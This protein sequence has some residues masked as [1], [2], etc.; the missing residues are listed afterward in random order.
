MRILLVQVL[1]YLLTSGGAHKA[2]RLLI[3]GFAARGHQCQVIAAGAA[4]AAGRAQLRA[5]LRARG[6]ELRA[7][8]P[9]EVVFQLNG[10][11]VHAVTGDFQ[12]YHRLLLE[13]AR[14]FAPDWVLVSEDRTFTLVELAIE[15]APGR[16][17]LLAHSQATL[18]FG[19]ESFDADPAKAR[20]LPQ[21]AGIISVSRYLQGY[22]REWGGCDAAVIPFPSYGDG[23][24][25]QLGRFDTGAVT[26]VNPA[27]IKGLPI[28]E[29]LARSLPDLP[30]AAVPTWASTATEIAALRQL[31][32]VAMYPQ[33]SDLDQ[34]FAQVR[35][36]LVPSLWG[37]SFG[38]VVVD[39]ML[40]GVPVLASAVGGLPEAKLGVDYL[41]PVEPIRAYAPQ[42]DVRST[43]MPII[44][45]QDV[46]PWRETLARLLSD[47]QLYE[48]VAAESRAAALAFVGALNV[49]RFVA[50][51]EQLHPAPLPAATASAAPEPLRARL[52]ALAPDRHA[53]LAL[54]L[55]QRAEAGPAAPAIPRLPRV[56][57]RPRFPISFAQQRLWFLHQLDPANPF[58]NTALSFELDAHAD[59]TL[60]QRSLDALAARHEALR[61]TLVPADGEP[62]QVINPPAPVPLAIADLRALPP[63]ERAA[64]AERLLAE[65][66]RAPFDLAQGPLLRALLLHTGDG[67]SRLL[68]VLHHII[69]DGWSVGVMAQDLDRCYAALAAGTPVD[70]PGPEIQYADYAVWQREQLRGE[71]LAQH[72]HY[73][74]GQF[75]EPAALLN[76]PT[77]RPR[78]AVKAYRGAALRRELPPPLRG[79]VERLSRQ[80]GATPFMTMLAVFA[81]LI[82]RSS[83]QTDLVIGTPIAGRTQRALEPVVGCFINMLPLRLR[84]DGAPSLRALIAQVRHTALEAYAHQELPIERLI[85]ALNLPRDLSLTPLFQVTF[86]VHNIPLPNLSASPMG[87]RFLHELNPGTAKFDLSLMADDSGFSL[88]YDSDLFDASTAARIAEQ[89]LTLLAAAL[90]APDQPLAELTL[91]TPAEQRQLAA[92]N[93]TRRAYR[94]DPVHVQIAEQAARTPAR[95]AVVYGEAS[96]RYDQLAGRVAQIAGALASLAVGPN[97]PV[98]VYLERGLELP[99]ALL[100]VLA[101][102]AAYLPLDPAYP[103]ER[104]STMLDDAGAP[105]L[106]TERRLA[107]RLPRFS[108]HVLWLDQIGPGG[109]APAGLAA[110]PDDLAY[111]IYTSGSTGRPK[112]VQIPHRALANFLAA[113]RVEPGLGPDDTLLAVTTI[114]FDIAGLELFLPLLVG[115]RLVLAPREVAV[116]GARLAALLDASGATVMQATPVTWRLL[117][118]AGW[119]GAPGLRALCGGEALP[120]ALAAELLPRTAELWNLYGPT[121]TTIWSTLE[122]VGAGPLTIG[123]PIANTE[124]HVLDE[125]GQ[126]TPIG[127]PGELCIGGDGLAVGYYGRPD[128]TAE[129]FIA[130]PHVAGGRLYRTGDLAR[131]RTD[132]RLECL[133]R[134]DQQVKLRGY[135][136]E[137]GEIESALLQHP[138]VQAAAV[139]AHAERPGEL[140]LVA[141]VALA[142]PQ[143]EPPDLRAYLRRQLPEYMLPAA[144]VALAAMPLTPNGK[145]DR[146][147]LP[148]P[149]PARLVH[150]AGSVAPRTPAEQAVAAIYAELLGLPAV[151]AEDDFFA[152]GGHSLLAMQLIARLGQRCGVQVALRQLFEAPTVA[153]LAAV[154]EVAGPAALA[155]IVAMPHTTAPPLSFAQERLWFL[156]QLVP[157]NPFYTIG[158]TLRLR[159][160]LDV[161]ALQHSLDALVAR[162]ATLRT[163]ILDGEDRPVQLVRPPA[164]VPLPL[165]ELGALAPAQAEAAMRELAEAELRRPFDLRAGPLFRATLLRLGPGEHVLTLTM[166]HSVADGWSLDV[167]LRDLTT[168]YR[169]AIVG[170]HAALPELPIQYADYAHWQREQLRGERLQS[171]LSYWRQQLAGAPLALELPTDRP[172]PPLQ[173]YNGAVYNFTLAAPLAEQL[174]ALAHQEHATLFLVLLTAFNV[175]LARYTGQRD[176]V[177]GTPIA[178]RERAE[179]AHMVGL[180]VNTL[181]LRT[182]LS[183]EPGFRAALQ[184][185]RATALAAYDHQDLPFEQL[186]EELQP[187]RDMSR[188]V[189]F[190]AFFLLQRDPV[191]ELRLPELELQPI[192]PASATTQFELTLGVT[193]TDAELYGWLE[194]NTDLF[195]QATIARLAGHFQ[196]LLE[197]VVAAPDQPI[198]TIDLLPA[199]ERA[200]LLAAPAAPAIAPRLVHE[201]IAA[202]AAARPAAEAVV[203]DGR[204][205]SYG[206]LER[207]A[208]RLAH[209]LLGQGVRPGDR[210][211]LCLER[212]P[213]QVIGM[214]AILKAG[215]AYLPLNAGT[216]RERLA[217]M[218]ADAGAAL[219]LTQAALAPELA[220]LGPRVLAIDALGTAMA[221]ADDSAPAVAVQPDWLAYVIYTSGSTGTPKGV[222]VEHG[223]LAHAYAA[224]EQSYQLGER[225]G[226]HLQ[227]AAL[228]FDVCTGDVVRALCSG[229]RLVICPQAIVLD[230][231]ALYELI[232]RERVD[233]AEFVPVVIRNLI[234]HVRAAGRSLAMFRLLV[235]GSDSW[236]MCEYEAL[237]DL[238]GPATRVVNS[239]GLT[240]MTID[241]AF[242]D[243]SSAHVAPDRLVPIGRPFPGTRLAILDAGGQLVPIGV[244]G[245][246]YLGGPGVARGYLGRP[247]LTAEHFVAD[248]GTPGR[249]LYRSGDLARYLPD[250]S[251]E[252]LGRSDGQVKI[253]GFRVELREIE[254]AL[255]E[256]PAV[257]AAAVIARAEAEHLPYL[258]AYLVIDPAW[259]PDHAAGAPFAALL[260]VLRARLRARLPDY[261]LPSAFVQLDAL[262]L[263]PSGKLNQAALPAPDGA[264]QSAVAFTAPR[265]STEET[266]A[267]I[268]GQVLNTTPIGVYDPFFDL[269]GHSLLAMQVVTRLRAAFA[270]DLP[271][272]C[273]FEAPTI[274][275]LAELIEARLIAEL[276]GL[277]DAEVETLLNPSY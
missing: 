97:V 92:W 33:T 191:R 152:L 83:A 20:L 140:R 135:R 75:A 31:P 141:Y 145:I 28:F 5:E 59:P 19:P 144:I 119:P 17:V 89:F 234:E 203:L 67:P 24:F 257:R 72:L 158:L 265:T 64:E 264:R 39:A 15:A 23:P 246:L 76:L 86:G 190:Q 213:E 107:E 115:A 12:Q 78:P 85:Q 10:A 217:F 229:A 226:C 208:N 116:D 43:P 176:L 1:D 223:S 218:L 106:L 259:Q 274:A 113:M 194:Y 14:V 114:S 105:V 62:Q 266:I 244:T 27:A 177:V 68:L 183:G 147:A 268:W 110:G 104:L 58:Y 87:L 95:T 173:T 111:I 225:P 46:A 200:M 142:Q 37:E 52:A 56:G 169:A 41:L 161:P 240:E 184:R 26:M 124:V 159:G 238:C 45:A 2:N 34:L 211:A 219:L 239:Y 103:A 101:A 243:G 237:R 81:A 82:S 143:A 276:E 178:N 35:V 131:W 108:G 120:P 11:E 149:D 9:E 263:L 189:L 253:R 73:W 249:R 3:E 94:A 232:V 36:L 121:E 153:A 55:R 77:D 168:C 272:R 137:L 182:D 185:V 209:Y 207:R 93:S 269:G 251:V 273:M 187:V 155:P 48:R 156:D 96:L 171:L 99:A 138:A 150:T 57:E 175:L 206:E 256:H 245:E 252:L 127:V 199:T 231:P 214:L 193:E 166:H 241:S 65:Q 117:L 40:R 151:G 79:A 148:A 98:G 133:G 129:R 221:A 53:L 198:G 50:Y 236:R 201:L 170:A 270:L 128:L 109:A 80:E 165:T 61:T 227:M 16:V 167:L 42:A 212:S 242:F 69:C 146:R 220:G 255:A 224:W 222:M 277:S 188:S 112:G 157:G 8:R 32:N 47:R 60:L 162:H 258:A 44:P 228:A 88:E 267:A 38:Q 230:A 205:L 122:R 70:W 215:A 186:V 247:D 195:E 204:A 254:A 261:M 51:L 271:L 71:R 102:G 4:G 100:G 202:Q 18:P 235:V 181:A 160:R 262:P 180:F 163:S 118:D 21:L 126:P 25:P 210:V 54:W 139:V 30:F 134:L 197:Q 22:I 123:R 74:Q 179:L 63:P 275:E 154:V 66:A 196:I 7:E 49:D 91:T 130:A 192:W 125:R 248:R 172:R 164:A 216:A 13:S 6:A 90:A 233:C 250:G 136:I 132:G 84:L 29:A 174:R 260:D